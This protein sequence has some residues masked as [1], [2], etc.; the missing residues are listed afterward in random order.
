MRFL[1]AVFLVVLLLAVVGYFRGW[2]AIT[3]THAGGRDQVTVG[4]ARDKIEHDTKEA[5]EGL[6]EL[7]AKAVEQVRSLG[8][9]ARAEETELEAIVTSADT[10]TR[11][12]VV[13]AGSE[14]IAFTVPSTVP[15]RRGS[16]TV[17]F[18][19]LRRDTRVRLWFRHV[20]DDRKLARIDVES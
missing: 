10:V 11:G 16:E 2:F 6:G 5:V 1:G 20:G 7:S 4:I 8:R 13:A 12:L 19:Q 15:I 17:G 14:S 3:T 18:D 9:K